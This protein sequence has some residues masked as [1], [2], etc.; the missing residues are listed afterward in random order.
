MT[1][2]HV[3]AGLYQMEEKKFNKRVMLSQSF[4]ETGRKIIHPQLI[5]YKCVNPFTTSQTNLID[6]S[7]YTMLMLTHVDLNNNLILF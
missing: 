1:G 5:I 4:Y 2:D 3:I 6:V 7:C